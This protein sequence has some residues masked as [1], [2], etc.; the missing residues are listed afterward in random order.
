M[1]TLKT[2]CRGEKKPIAPVY[3]PRGASSSSAMSCMA[4]TLGAPVTDPQGNSARKMSWKPTSGRNSALTVE[5]ICQSVGSARR[6]RALR[7][8]APRLRNAAQVVAHQVDDH[9]V[10]AAVLGVVAQPLGNFAVFARGA[11]ARRGAFHGARD[12]APAAMG[13]PSRLPPQWEPPSSMRKNSSGENE[14]M[15]G[16]AANAGTRRSRPAAARAAARRAPPRCPA[17]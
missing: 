13:S 1:A 3:T 6:R 17:P 4:R 9:H 15:C 7:L 12:D 10:F 14:R 5:V 8:H 11:A 2:V 16:L